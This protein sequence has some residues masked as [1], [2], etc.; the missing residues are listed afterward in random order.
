MAAPGRPNRAPAFRSRIVTLLRWLLPL[1]ALAILSTLFLL[2]RSPDPEDAIPYADVDAE[3]LANRPQMTAPRFAG[4]T[5]DGGRLTLSASNAVPDGRES[6]DLT[7]LVLHWRA[8][9]G[10]GADVSA[11]SAELRDETIELGQGVRMTLSSGYVLS[12]PSMEASTVT[13]ALVA[14]GPVGG[15]APFGRIDAGA[16][17]LRAERGSAA[18]GTGI[19]HVLDFTGGVRLIYQP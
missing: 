6:A 3:A 8:P 13:D 9:D 7:D 1:S 10:L 14:P 15:L 5:E 16:M 2:S 19:S 11:G 17:A 18:N 12:A 4:V